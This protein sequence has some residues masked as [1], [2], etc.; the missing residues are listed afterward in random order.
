MALAL[1]LL[2]SPLRCPAVVLQSRT[3]SIAMSAQ[4]RKQ[5]LDE[6]V[7]KL[8]SDNPFYDRYAQKLAA[9]REHKPDEFLERVTKV[10]EP[11]KPAPPLE[12]P[13]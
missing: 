11:P 2:R 4:R 3:R 6:A 12:K 10:V 13:R 7:D 8:K 9:M 1:R 5:Q